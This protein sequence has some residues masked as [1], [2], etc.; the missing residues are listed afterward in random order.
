ML[1]LDSE[2]ALLLI[3]FAFI[4]LMEYMTYSRLGTIKTDISLMSYRIRELEK[5]W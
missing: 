5:K 3:I 4:P 1:F 2:E